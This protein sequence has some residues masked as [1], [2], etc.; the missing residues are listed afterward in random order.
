MPKSTTDHSWYTSNTLEEH[1][2]SDPLLFRHDEL[3]NIL[4]ARGRVTVAGHS[5]H[6]PA[7]E[8][9]SREGNPVG[10]VLRVAVGN[11][12]ATHLIIRVPMGDHKSV[13]CKWYTTTKPM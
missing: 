9:N 5:V 1:E 12:N 13:P 10:P 3:G 8:A 4:L 2:A 6:T 7:H 11:F